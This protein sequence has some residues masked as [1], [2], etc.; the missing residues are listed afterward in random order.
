MLFRSTGSGANVKPGEI[1]LQDAVSFR[2]EG[3]QLQDAGEIQGASAAYRRAVTVN[4]SYAEAYNDLGVVLES[5]GN[6]QEAEEA[7]KSAV[8]LKPDF[9]AAHSNLASLY[10]ETGRTKEAA[11]HWS[12]RIRL[13]PPDDPWVIKAREKVTHYQLPITETPREVAE[14]KKQAVKLA[15]SRLILPEICH[16]VRELRR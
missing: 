13:G 9:G 1:L 12:A 14:N 8:T 16:I 2:A 4:P 5:L 10:E 3:R 11:E 15:M 7:Y 6:L